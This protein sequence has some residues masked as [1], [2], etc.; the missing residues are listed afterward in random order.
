MN[1]VD[2][3]TADRGIHFPFL[4]G[5]VVMNNVRVNNITGDYYGVQLVSSGTVSI[6]HIELYKTPGGGVFIDNF[7]NTTTAKN[8]TL[9]DIDTR[10]DTG[11]DGIYVRSR[12]AISAKD[13]YVTPYSGTNTRE[14]GVYLDNTGSP[15]KAGVTVGVAT[16]TRNYFAYFTDNGF[17]VLS[18]GPVTIDKTR[19]FKAAGNGMVVSNRGGGAGTGGVTLTNSV[20]DSNKMEWTGR[21]RSPPT[22]TW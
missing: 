8:V 3:S 2:A 22:V 16:L 9:L 17:S 14:S 19:V 12:G 7:S 11:G 4:V 21:F 1:Y 18:D 13:L 6:S 5:N 10:S 20:I 15:V